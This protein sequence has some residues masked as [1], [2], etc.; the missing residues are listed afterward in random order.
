L[1]AISVVRSNGRCNIKE[2]GCDLRLY[3]GK[4]MC[5]K[6][7]KRRGI[8]RKKGPAT[9]PVQIYYIAYS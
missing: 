5:M 2:A 3:V 4:C 8:L 7:I 1:K 6:V 9:E